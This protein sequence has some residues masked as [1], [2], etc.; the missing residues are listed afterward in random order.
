MPRTGRPT[1]PV[2]LKRML[3]NP[4]KRPLRTPITALAPIVTLPHPIAELT[5]TA[6]VQQ[7]LDAGASAWISTTDQLGVLTL[8]G[9]AWDER[10]TLRAAAMVVPDGMD[11]KTLRAWGESTRKELRDLEKQITA[12]LSLLGLTPTDR[13]RLGVAEV[14]AR[15]KLEELRE[16]RESRGGRRDGSPPSRQRTSRV[17]TE[18]TS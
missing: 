4:G 1:K 13:S 14:K 16:R 6:F 3:G 12:W 7:L 10:R 11:P 15:T 8:L 2:E 18:M 5:G 9:D 17:A